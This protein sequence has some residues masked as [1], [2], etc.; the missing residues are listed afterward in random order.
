MVQQ[1]NWELGLDN[2]SPERPEVLLL[3]AVIH[4]DNEA[5]ALLYDDRMWQDN[6]RGALTSADALHTRDARNFVEQVA[7]KH[8]KPDT[9]EA[10][11]R[12]LADW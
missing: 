10:A 6:V 3:L 9:R 1:I 8:T 4:H 7:L 11:A 2:F 12:L 5:M